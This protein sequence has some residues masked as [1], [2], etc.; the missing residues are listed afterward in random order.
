ME[1]VGDEWSATNEK[2]EKE[3]NFDFCQLFHEKMEIVDAMFFA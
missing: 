3:Q 2:M 1:I